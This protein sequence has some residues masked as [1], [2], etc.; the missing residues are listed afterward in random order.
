MTTRTEVSEQATTWTDALFSDDIFMADDDSF[1]MVD[2]DDNSMVVSLSV[3]GGAV[4]TSW[5]EVSG[6]SVTDYMIADHE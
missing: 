1:F 2:D 3:V 6:V 4:T 5:S